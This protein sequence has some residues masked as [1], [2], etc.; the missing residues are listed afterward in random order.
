MRGRIVDLGAR[1]MNAT[2]RVLLAVSG[3]RVGRTD[4]DIPVVI[5]EDRSE[6]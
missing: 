5:L 4:R 3:G 6:I 1:V 2:R